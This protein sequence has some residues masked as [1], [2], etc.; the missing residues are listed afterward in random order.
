MSDFFKNL[1]SFNKDIPIPIKN[2]YSAFTPIEVNEAKKVLRKI[3]LDNK[4]INKLI[5]KPNNYL[6][7]IKPSI[8]SNK[9]YKIGFK[10]LNDLK[11]YMNIILNFSN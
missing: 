6:L 10:N 1:N 9:T 8:T 7:T 11:R 2:K 3:G 5:N 4:D